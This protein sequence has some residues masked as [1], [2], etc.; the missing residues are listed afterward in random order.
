MQKLE[1]R[2]CTKSGK[3]IKYLQKNLY[4]IQHLVLKGTRITSPALNG[5]QGFATTHSAVS[6]N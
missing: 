3:S 1:G 2:V 6:L 5:R 4:Q